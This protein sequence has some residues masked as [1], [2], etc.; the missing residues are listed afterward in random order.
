MKTKKDL[1][2]CYERD[3]AVSFQ[4]ISEAYLLFNPPQDRLKESLFKYFGKHYGRVFGTA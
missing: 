3:I 4:N 1:Q 2:M